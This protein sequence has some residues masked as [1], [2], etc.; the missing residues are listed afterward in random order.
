MTKV[1]EKKS[2]SMPV[3]Y[4]HAAGID[5][6]SRQH[7]VAIGQ[8]KEHVR[9]FGVYTSDILQLCA[10]LK[11]SNI[12]TVA[13]ES[14]G[15]YWKNLFVMLQQHGLNP[16]LVNGRFTKNLKGRKTDV[17]DCQ[18]IQ[19]M[20]SLGLL[21]DC[22]QPDSFTEQIRNLV[23]H[24]SSVISQ[25]GDSSQRMQQSLRGM[26]VRLDVA[27]A[28]ITGKS[29]IAIIEAI[30]NGER[31][32]DKLSL[33]TKG[34]MKKSAQEIARALTGFYRADHLFQ[35]RQ[36]YDVWKVFQKQL[37]EVDEELNNL[38]EQQLANDNKNDLVLP[39][40]DKAKK[41]SNKNNPGFNIEY[42]AFR[43]FNGINLMQV[44]GIGPGTLLTIISELGENIDK[45][46]SAKN[47]CSWLRLVPNKKISGG[48]VLSNTIQRG[49]N[50]LAIAL[51]NAANTIGNM[52]A[53]VPL[54]S[55]FRRIAFR[56]G[57]PAAI[58]ATA[59][60]LAVIIWNMLTK[61]Q[62]Y[63]PPSNEKYEER[64]RT[65]TLKNVQRKILRMGIKVEDLQFAVN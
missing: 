11:E 47:F 6:G 63:N 32:A 10:W 8:G 30:L 29:G 48:K 38:L 25:A 58:T 17:M 53:T 16:I 44:P 12:T 18:F 27:V 49:T 23:R 24:R 20:H 39:K 34:R 7:Y 40:N 59:R 52:K 13:L 19:K 15:S 9:C 14:T 41:Q 4:A 60:K 36:H 46:N 22:F 31:D 21:P 33:L 43:L 51:R 55:F 5:V 2:E 45:F 61:H 50:T 64:I 62:S 65:M 26:N 56:Y 54:T 37:T 1:E 3:H 42:K 28:D 57:R 35:L